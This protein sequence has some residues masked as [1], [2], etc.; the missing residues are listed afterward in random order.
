MK[1]TFPDTDSTKGKL[2]NITARP[3]FTL[4]RYVFKI[5]FKLSRFFTEY[6]STKQDPFSNS[7]YEDGDVED[8]TLTELRMQC[9]WHEENIRVLLKAPKNPKIR[10]STANGGGV[11]GRR[12]GG[13]R[14]GALE[15]AENMAVIESP[16]TKEPSATK[17]KRKKVEIHNTNDDAGKSPTSASRP[18]ASQSVRN[19]P[20]IRTER[21]V[22]PA[23]NPA[24]D[25]TQP[26]VQEKLTTHQPSPPPCPGTPP[27]PTGTPPTDFSADLKISNLISTTDTLGQEKLQ[28]VSNSCNHNGAASVGVKPPGAKS[29]FGDG[30]SAAAEAET[31]GGAHEALATSSGS[32]QLEALR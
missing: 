27:P 12:S 21:S 28:T 13:N 19:P 30:A 20:R 14:A 9:A 10:S 29:S 25:T 24:V 6:Q 15:D 7:Q 2:T 3:T 26:A 16:P 23:A 11:G 18:A 17:G 4:C 22:A 5:K 1:N 32:G 8:L 31:T